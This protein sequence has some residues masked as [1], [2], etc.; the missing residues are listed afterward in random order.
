LPPP[1]LEPVAQV[2][3]GSPKELTVDR[4]IR[5]TIA[6][7]AIGS[8]IGWSTGAALLV[9]NAGGLRDMI[10]NSANPPVMLALMAVP[11]GWLFGIGYLAT[12]LMFLSEAD[13]A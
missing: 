4:L 3:V 6:N 5:F 10:V 9:S 8:T 7:I 2:R 11:V 12:A 1:A 13:E